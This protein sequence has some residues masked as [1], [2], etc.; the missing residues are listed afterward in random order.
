MP[1]AQNNAAK[2]VKRSD[3]QPDRRDDRPMKMSEQCD[4]MRIDRA[5]HYRRRKR[6]PRFPPPIN[7]TLNGYEVWESDFYAYLALIQ[8]EPLPPSS[9]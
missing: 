5:T 7:L 8:R 3:G 4:V 9:K 1:T 2:N 6:D